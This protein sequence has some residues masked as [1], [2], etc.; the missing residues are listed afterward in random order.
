MPLRK[1][2]YKAKKP[3][4]KSYRTQR[5][6]LVSRPRVNH[7]VNKLIRA[8]K[9]KQNAIPYSQLTKRDKMIFKLSNNTIDYSLATQQEWQDLQKELH[10]QELLQQLHKSMD[11][12][13]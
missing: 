12:G 2:N 11:Q 9:A 7:Q 13:N 10:E 6:K 5:P 3:V 4:N 8:T 1:S